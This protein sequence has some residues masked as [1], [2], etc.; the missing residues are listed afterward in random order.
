MARRRTTTVEEGN[1]LVLPRIHLQHHTPLDDHGSNETSPLELA[2]AALVTA[3]ED[4]ELND[5]LFGRQPGA[6]GQGASGTQQQ[7][8]SR[9]RGR[10]PGSTKKTSTPA[11]SRHAPTGNTITPNK[12]LRHFSAQVA[13]K[14]E[15]KGT[16]TYNEV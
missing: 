8:I 16:T 6:D 2:V 14:V 10:P 13:A 5:A 4:S 7:K 11:T 15:E 1:R 3:A 9:G 12:G